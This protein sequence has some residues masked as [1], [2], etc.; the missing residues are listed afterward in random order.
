MKKFFKVIVS[1]TLVLAVTLS[2]TACSKIKKMSDIY[3]FDNPTSAV[4]VLSTATK[5][6]VGDYTDCEGVVGGFAILSRTV[7][8]QNGSE[9]SKTTYDF[10]LYDW[11]N[12]A[13][14]DQE[15][16]LEVKVSPYIN[17][18]DTGLVAKIPDEVDGDYTVFYNGDKSFST[19]SVDVTKNDKGLEIFRVG[20]FVIYSDEG[21]LVAV[22]NKKVNV[23]DIFAMENGYF[24]R[25]DT[26]ARILLVYDDEFNLYGKATLPTYKSEISA[27]SKCFFPLSNG[28]VLVQYLY[29][30]DQYGDEYDVILDGNKYFVKQ[31][32][33]N[34]AENSIEDVRLDY[35]VTI[36]SDASS[37][38]SQ[39]RYQ[40]KDKVHNICYGYKIE[41][42]RISFTEA[43]K[44]IFSMTNDGEIMVFEKSFKTQAYT[45]EIALST[46]SFL[47]INV[48]D[49]LVLID[50]KGSVK[51]TFETEISFKSGIIEDGNKYYSLDG[52]LILDNT[53][54]SYVKVQDMKGGILFSKAVT[55]DTF[56]NVEYYI[57]TGGSFKLIATD[58]DTNDTARETSSR[59]LVGTDYICED[60][61]VVETKTKKETTTLTTVTFYNAN[62]EKLYE[63]LPPQDEKGDTF[64]SYKVKYNGDY[65]VVVEVKLDKWDADSQAF[66]NTSELIVFES[67]KR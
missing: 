29:V 42:K 22:E 31:Q 43:E 11:K 58:Y 50:N 36:C 6:T 53:D 55:A 61:Y 56:N 14:V 19:E 8:V 63:Y 41:E 5:L 60:V 32:I 66:V 9:P 1:L 2:V 24:Y 27:L 64:K 23:A 17:V 16:G 10:A 59:V 57:M 25:E 48:A 54:A 47:S 45:L 44:A 4:S 38:E 51:N 39:A 33:Y 62:G 7:T 40:V 3:D 49:D 37:L 52:K 21:Q 34:A 20:D 65:G 46:D 13:F 12:K 18:D 15:D 28:N 30:A 67:T 26:A 35:V